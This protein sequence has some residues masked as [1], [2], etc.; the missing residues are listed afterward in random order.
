VHQ[1]LRPDGTLGLS[2]RPDPKLV[3]YEGV[4]YYCDMNY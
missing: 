3:L 4:V 1:Y 2:G